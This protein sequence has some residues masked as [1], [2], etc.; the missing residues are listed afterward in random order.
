MKYVDKWLWYISDE[1]DDPEDFEVEDLI[2]T[3]EEELK[4]IHDE[5]K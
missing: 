3:Y 4:V 1:S 5:K 2:E